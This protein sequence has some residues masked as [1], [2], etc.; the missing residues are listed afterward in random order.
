[1]HLVIFFDFIIILIQQTS[2]ISRCYPP[3]PGTRKKL[4]DDEA[5]RDVEENVKV[6]NDSEATDDKEE[7]DDAGTFI[8]E[9]RGATIDDLDDT[10]ES[11]P[12]GQNENDVDC[13]PFVCAA[14]EASTSQPPKRSSG[15]FADEDELIFEVFSVVLFSLT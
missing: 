14:P 6:A 4:E 3:A 11:S 9:Y 2:T 12:S 5:M 15:G 1:L 7:E 10:A 8:I 13:I